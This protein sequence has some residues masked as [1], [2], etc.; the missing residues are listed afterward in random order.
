MKEE[1]VLKKKLRKRL[2]AEV[3]GKSG[4]PKRTMRPSVF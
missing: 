1:R 4:E 3:E 2:G